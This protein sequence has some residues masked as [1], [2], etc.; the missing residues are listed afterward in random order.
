M[1]TESWKENGKGKG[2]LERTYGSVF[3]SFFITSSQKR[4]KVCGIKE[5]FER[6]VHQASQT[7]SCDD[8][9][10]QDRLEK[11]IWSEE[12]PFC[13]DFIAIEVTSELIVTSKKGI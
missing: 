7:G 4:N 3:D 1:Q 8:D 10:D 13:I 5:M 11:T 6:R 9:D 2:N 12:W